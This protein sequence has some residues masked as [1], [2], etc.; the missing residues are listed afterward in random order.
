MKG[1]RFTCIDRL[2]PSKYSQTSSNRRLGDF[3]S[4]TVIFSGPIVQSG[5]GGP[6]KSKRRA[7]RARLLRS[8]STSGTAQR[9]SR[10]LACVVKPRPRHPQDIPNVAHAD[11]DRARAWSRRHAHGSQHQSLAKGRAQAAARDAHQGPRAAPASA[12]AGGRARESGRLPSPI[13]ERRGTTRRAG[14]TTPLLHDQE[15][16]CGFGWLA[17]TATHRDEKSPR[18]LSVQ[19]YDSPQNYLRLLQLLRKWTCRPLVVKQKSWTR[20]EAAQARSFGSDG[21]VGS[22]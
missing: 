7:R 14:A 13:T 4:R 16:G 17:R 18:F 19:R 11:D 10:G 3:K 6:H 8:P 20:R 12:G 1:E 2:H 22:P 9:V 21:G 5:R 15:R